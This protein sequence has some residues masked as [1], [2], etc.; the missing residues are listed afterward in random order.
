[1]DQKPPRTIADV[2]K[3]LH[4]TND[5][6]EFMEQRFQTMREDIDKLETRFE[7][8]MDAMDKQV[9]QIRLTLAQWFGVALVVGVIL[10]AITITIIANTVKTTVH[11]ER[12]PQAASAK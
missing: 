1:M 9:V 12:I 4:M 6:M 11:Y 10:Q 3:L 7:T 2:W 5:K 8:K